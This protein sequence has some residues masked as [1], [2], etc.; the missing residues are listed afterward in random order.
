V[1][2]FDREGNRRWPEP[3][4]VEG[5]VLLQ[6]QPA[7]LPVLTFASMIQQRKSSRGQYETKT[8]VLCIDKRTGREVFG[9]QFR[10]ATNS[11]RLAGDP[12]AKTVELGLQRT[13][14]TLT[15]TD[16]PPKPK[17]DQQD[18]SGKGG[19]TRKWG[20]GPLGGIWKAIRAAIDG[21]P[22]E[23]NEP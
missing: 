8:S 23:S 6:G 21:V 12:Q 13:T 7:R 3:V 2:A 10:G 16:Q 17:T 22:S 20:S 1:Y 14:V 18:A 5:Q 11:F 19:S 15:F 9:E 4:K